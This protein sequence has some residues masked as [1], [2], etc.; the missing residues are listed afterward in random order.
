P[1]GLILDRFGIALASNSP[2]YRAILVAEQTRDEG[3]TLD[4]EGTLKAFSEIV[5]LSDREIARIMKARKNNRAFVP[6]TVKDDLD[7]EQV[8]AVEL[9]L[10]DLPGVSIEIDQKRVYPFGGI[11]SHILGYVAVPNEKDIENDTDP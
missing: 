5:P 9:N 6:I 11:T 10:P 4:V 2:S 8:N 3:G 7:W 1:R